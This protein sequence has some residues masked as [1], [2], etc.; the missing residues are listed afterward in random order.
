MSRFIA[1]R[2]HLA[3]LWRTNRPLTAVGLVMLPVLVFS[4][5]GLLLDGR[6][7]A[8]APAWLKPAKFAASI[9]IY[10]LTLAWAFRFLPEQQRTRRVVGRLSAVVLL[11][12]MAIIVV[13][14]A[15]GKPSHFNASTVL[16]SV[17]F[18]VMGAAIVTQTASSIAVA[19]ALWRQTF[20]D[21][22]LGWALRLGLAITIAGA[23]VGGMMAAPTGAQIA[24]LKA[25]HD[26]PLGAHSV[27]APDGSPGLAGTGWSREHGDLRVAHFMG[28]H[29]LQ[30]L[31]LLAIGL[32][33]GRRKESERV[34]LVLV[35]AAGY[36]GL[37]GILLWQALRGQSLVAPD[38]K[39]IGVLLAWLALTA[40]AAW[41]ALARR[42]A[43]RHSPASGLVK[44]EEAS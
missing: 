30:T 28:L 37:F 33:R 27:G 24:L 11:L 10:A 2:T 36:A 35:G 19:V 31:P 34:R 3:Q 42:P 15:R 13:Q 9:A 5:F 43:P 1:L 20:A 23:S 25:G 39:A 7:I 14:A 12:E 21:R 38:G 17:L 18:N 4:L 44:G 16:D 40:I 8:G 22:A 26:T 41:P 32:R 29:A 6:S